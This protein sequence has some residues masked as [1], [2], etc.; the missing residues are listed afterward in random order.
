[1]TVHKVRTLDADFKVDSTFVKSAPTCKTFRIVEHSPTEIKIH[2]H[3][4]T[5]DIPYCDTFDVE[6]LLLVRGL[7]PN[8]KCCVV[9]IGLNTIWHKSSMM[10]GTLKSSAEQAAREMN[11]DLAK[12]F[13]QYP[14]VENKKPVP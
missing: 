3:N 9:Q 11:A 5:R 10:K 8:S 13:K 1:M 12:K 4:K 2:S 14:F 7:K 6:D